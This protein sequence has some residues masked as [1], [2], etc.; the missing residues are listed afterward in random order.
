MIGDCTRFAAD[1]RDH[2]Q[3]VIAVLDA[4]SVAHVLREQASGLVV[5]KGLY[6]SVRLGH[7]LQPAFRRIGILH[8]VAQRVR[9]AQQIALFVVGVARHMAQRIRDFGDV[10]QRVIGVSGLVAQLV[11]HARQAVD[12]VV[13]ILLGVS[14]GICFFRDIARQVIVEALA[15]AIGIGHLF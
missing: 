11:D 7:A 9:F 10:V 13:Q 12:L 5:I 15:C 14:L 8:L 1:R 3:L 6:G 2:P 4:L